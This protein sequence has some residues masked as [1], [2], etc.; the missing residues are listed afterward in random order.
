MIP[1]KTIEELIIKHSTLEK[2]LSSGQIDKKL[3]AEKSKEYSD[4]NEIIENARKYLL[5]EDDKK[6]LEKI[7]NDSSAD[8]ELKDM[9][10]IELSDLKTEFEINEKKLKLFLLPKDE[11]L[12]GGM[13]CGEV[14][15]V[16][17]EILKNSVKHC[18]SLPDDDIAK[19]MR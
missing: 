1:A 9:A 5:Y 15:L 12:M 3:F 13:S 18:I 14:S 7:L 6:D 17:W 19:T 10:E 4:V 11:S 8:K 16:P 2:D